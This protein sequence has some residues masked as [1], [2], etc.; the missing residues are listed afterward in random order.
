MRPDL[1]DLWER[2]TRVEAN[3]LIGYLRVVRRRLLLYWLPVE[4]APEVLS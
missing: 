4:V 1:T 2:R 3:L